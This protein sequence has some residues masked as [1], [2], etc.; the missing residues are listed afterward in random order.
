MHWAAH[1]HT[2]AEII[3]ERVQAELP[4][5]G[6]TNW[7]GIKPRKIDIGIAKNYLNE[8]ELEA[9]NRIYIC[10]IGLLNLMIF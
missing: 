2:A 4:N 10:K 8:E 1:G 5:M 7:T 3:S 6:L 9:L